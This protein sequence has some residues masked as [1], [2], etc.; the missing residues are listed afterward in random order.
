MTEQAAVVIWLGLAAW[1]GFGMVV[2]LAVITFGMSRLTHTATPVRVRLLLLPGLAA[3]WPVVLLR[4]A[5]V[6]AP[7]DRG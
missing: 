6:R 5:G 1:L 3:L 4:I 2:G 7:E